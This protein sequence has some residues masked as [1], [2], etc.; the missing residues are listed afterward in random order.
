MCF[1]HIMSKGM[2]FE[3][4]TAL[5]TLQLSSHAQ[6]SNQKGF[7]IKIHRYFDNCINVVI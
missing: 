1:G 3:E 4:N 6:R 2:I 5:T 7:D